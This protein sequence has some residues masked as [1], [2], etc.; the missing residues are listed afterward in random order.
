MSMNYTA[1]R[2]KYLK[3]DGTAGS[4]YRLYTYASGTTTFKATYTDATLATPN[5]YATDGSGKKYITLNA[6]GEAQVWLGTGAYTMVVAD[7]SGAEKETTNGV[8]DPA[9]AVSDLSAS[10]ASTTDAAKGA[11]LVGFA[12]GLNYAVGTLGWS[13]AH[14][15]GIDISQ[16]PYGAKLDGSEDVGAILNEVWAAY[17]GVPIRIPAGTVL[18]TTPS[19]FYSAATIGAFGPM[20]KIYGD[21]IGVTFVDM[22]IPNGVAWDFDADTHSPFNA[23]MGGH[24]HGLSFKCGASTANMIMLRFLNTYLLKIEACHFE[25]TNTTGTSIGIELRNGA[26]A[27]DGWNMVH[28][29][30]LW[31]ENFSGWGIKADGDSGRNEGSFTKMTHVF[32]QQCGTAPTQTLITAITKANPC[33]ISCPGHTITAGQEVFI[34][35][36]GGMVELG[37]RYTVASV[38]AG[39]SVTLSG[40]NSTGY[41]SFTGLGTIE[42][43]TTPTSGGMIWKGQLLYQDNC[44]FT[45]NQNAALYIKGQSG[46]GIGYLGVNTTFENNHARHLYCTGITAFKGIQ[47]QLHANDSYRHHTAI[48]FDGATY[49]VRG[50]DIEGTV[51]RATS[52]N[53][54]AKAFKISGSNAQLNTC[55][56]YRTVWDSYDNNADAPQVRFEGWTFDTVQQCCDVVALDATTTLLRPS[57]KGIGCTTPLRLR[58]GS[59]YPSSSGEWVAWQLGSGG[60]SVSNSGLSSNT[61]YFVY[62]YDNA[63]VAALELSTTVPTTDST[64]CYQVKTGDATRLLVGSVETDGSSQFKLTAG[65][66]LNPLALPG[67]QVGVYS[68]MWTDSTGDL[69]VKYA[70]LPTSDTDGTVVGTQ[71]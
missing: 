12:Y 61:R 8:I 25:G 22:R 71:T 10:L 18:I 69:R 30:R 9:G 32:V 35:G 59:T 44:A 58:G 34:K 26:Y 39:V 21:G 60:I 63:N 49:T 57:S 5:T 2:F 13:A 36:V 68:Y 64:T 24:L 40:V 53:R 23:T 56:V 51:V 65:G 67:S 19:T 54:R 38:V 4:G 55:R 46:L 45:L 14:T 52:G 41:T 33:V 31:I 28:L 16:E 43:I 20:P 11:G 17:P 27:D 50:V 7:A 15:M 3:D 62:L 1:G 42:A 70:T 29:D 37:G 48:E 66:W 6:R 47:L